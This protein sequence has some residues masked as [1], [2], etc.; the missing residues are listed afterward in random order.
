MS[1]GSGHFY[2]NEPFSENKGKGERRKGGKKRGGGGGGG[3]GEREREREKKH[4]L[5]LGCPSCH[6]ISYA[7]GLCLCGEGEYQRRVPERSGEDRSGVLQ[8]ELVPWGGLH[9]ASSTS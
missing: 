4:S 6:P 2:I 9:E 3:K 1:L 5:S 8:Q 7:S